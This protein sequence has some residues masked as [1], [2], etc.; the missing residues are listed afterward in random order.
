MKET[1]KRAAAIMVGTAVVLWSSAAAAST[2]S[3]LSA[4][5]LTQMSDWIDSFGEAL[6]GPLGKGF[7]IVALFGSLVYWAVGSGD[8]WRKVAPVV[9]VALGIVAIPQIVSALG[10]GGLI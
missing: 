8:A 2:S 4:T 9:I 1:A 6:T 3:G 10:F 5:G 7:A